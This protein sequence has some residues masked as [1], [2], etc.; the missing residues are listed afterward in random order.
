MTT[1]RV[2]FNALVI[3]GLP[4]FFA[5]CSK[6]SDDAG[7]SAAPAEHTQPEL[8]APA[9]TPS[10]TASAPVESASG[11]LTISPNPVAVCPKT[12]LGVATVSWRTAGVR[13]IEVR[14]GAPDGKLFTR[15]GFRG[16]EKTGEWVKKGTSFFLQN[17]TN[18]AP[19][20]ADNTLA[21][22]DVET[23]NGPCR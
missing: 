15:A 22:L 5:G 23:V 17:V 10:A 8:Q 12:G 6:K 13:D 19:T 18:G 4:A 16:S 11:A 9:P 20:T 7:A 1:R 3:A 14:V 21:R 2:T